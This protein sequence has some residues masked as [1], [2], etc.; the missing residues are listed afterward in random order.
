MGEGA[1]CY[2][3][4]AIRPVE[5]YVKVLCAMCYAVPSNAKYCVNVR[6]CAW[7]P[8]EPPQRHHMLDGSPS[9]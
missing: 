6:S 7:W 3:P 8:Q 4:C 9:I 5:N 2:V 1:M